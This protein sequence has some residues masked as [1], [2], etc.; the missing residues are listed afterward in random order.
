MTHAGPSC[1][2]VQCFLP[3]QLGSQPVSDLRP[4]DSLRILTHSVLTITAT[5]TLPIVHLEKLISYFYLYM[6][7]N[8]DFPPSLSPSHVLISIHDGYHFSN[9]KLDS[10]LLCIS[11]STYNR[12]S[13]RQ[14][15]FP[16]V[17]CVYLFQPHAHVLSSGSHF[18]SK[19][20]SHSFIVLSL[21]LFIHFP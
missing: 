19:L 18:T 15:F 20:V 3:L 9:Q 4:L 5:H 17:S 8:S 10:L 7:S 6:T 21:S 14:H 11:R 1:L 13:I 2:H 12:L 16:T